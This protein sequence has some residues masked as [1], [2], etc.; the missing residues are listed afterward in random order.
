VADAN[1]TEALDEAF[2]SRFDEKIA[3]PR[4]DVAVSVQLEEVHILISV[5]LATEVHLLHVG[6]SWP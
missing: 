5:S 1:P 4:L 6:A 2:S 3:F